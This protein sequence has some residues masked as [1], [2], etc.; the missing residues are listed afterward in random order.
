MSGNGATNQ[1]ALIELENVSKIFYTDAV[2]STC[3]PPLVF[4]S[5][6]ARARSP[7]CDNDG[8]PTHIHRRSPMSGMPIFRRPSRRI[9]RRTCRVASRSG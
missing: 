1:A 4:P 5:C 2:V 9:R 7:P 8:W 6:V 3:M